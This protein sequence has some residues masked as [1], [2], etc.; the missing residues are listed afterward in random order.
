MSNK[1]KLLDK[2][3]MTDPVLDQTW[4]GFFRVTRIVPKTGLPDTKIVIEVVPNYNHNLNPL[5]LMLDRPTGIVPRIKKNTVI[6]ISRL[7]LG[8]ACSYLA[9]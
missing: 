2:G 4:L 9:E 3:K 7:T 8:D 1:N 6:P 5:I